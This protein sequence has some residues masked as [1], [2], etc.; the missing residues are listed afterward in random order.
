MSEFF[1]NFIRNDLKILVR[2]MSYQKDRAILMRISGQNV[3]NAT[4][5]AKNCVLFKALCENNI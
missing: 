1:D 3:R 5:R 2:N 4:D